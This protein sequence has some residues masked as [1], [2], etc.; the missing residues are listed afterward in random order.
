MSNS[1]K[2]YELVFQENQSQYFEA[3]DSWINKWLEVTIYPSQGGLSVILKDIT[4]K[5]RI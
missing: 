5:K 1:K 4:S 2:A 3:F